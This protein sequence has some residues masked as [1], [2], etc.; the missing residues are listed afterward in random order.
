MKE[1]AKQVR[2]FLLPI[3]YLCKGL[4][5]SEIQN[6]SLRNQNVLE[7]QVIFLPL[8]RVTFSPFVDKRQ[9]QQLIACPLHL[10]VR[11]FQVSFVS[12][13]PR[14]IQKKKRSFSPER[15]FALVTD[16]V[17]NDLALPMC[18]HLLSAL[19]M[20]AIDRRQKIV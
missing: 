16:S 4:Q 6:S 1:L 5:E 11:L 14:L 19:D 9:R 13:Y 2:R 7:M 8:F 10:L 12:R 18:S 15:R 17:P 3:F 20:V